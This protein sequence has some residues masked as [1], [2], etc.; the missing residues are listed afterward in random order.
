MIASDKKTFTTLD[1]A[2]LWKNQNARENMKKR[3]K[4]RYKV[5]VTKNY[6][7]MKYYAI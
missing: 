1:Y 3:K 6:K 7:S 5:M 4:S 2:Y